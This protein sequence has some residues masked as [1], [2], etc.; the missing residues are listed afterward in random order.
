M[1]NNFFIEKGVQ[2]EKGGDDRVP[3]LQGILHPIENSL[4]FLKNRN[5]KNSQTFLEGS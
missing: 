2:M 5:D 3:F 1:I 4:K